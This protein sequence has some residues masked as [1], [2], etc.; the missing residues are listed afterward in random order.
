MGE[1]QT[2][3]VPGTALFFLVILAIV[4]LLGFLRQRNVGFLIL[5]FVMLLEGVL[6]LARQFVFNFFLFHSTSISAIQKSQSV[7]LTSMVALGVNVVLWILAIL[8]ALLVVFHRS[9]LQT[10]AGAHPPVS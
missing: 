6:N 4:W 9:K 7:A 2:F 3:L 10:D 1:L 5:A 8:G